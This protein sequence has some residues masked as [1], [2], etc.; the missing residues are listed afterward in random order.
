VFVTCT[1]EGSG[2]RWF[3]FRLQEARHR[4]EAATHAR[5]QAQK[6]AEEARIAEEARLREEKR[7]HERC[8]AGKIVFLLCA[9][10]IAEL[11]VCNCAESWRKTRF[12]GLRKR[13]PLAKQ[14]SR[15]NGLP[16]DA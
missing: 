13:L 4:E 16:Q 6:A 11:R 7:A 5:I 12:D 10:C 2:C 9:S 8:V 15:V 14:L 3:P 1:D